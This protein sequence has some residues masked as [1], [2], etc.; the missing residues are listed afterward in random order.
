MRYKK[1]HELSIVNYYQTSIGLR[2]VAPYEGLG[3]WS[4]YNAH[5]ISRY[6]ERMKLDIEDPLEVAVTFFMRNEGF[7]NSHTEKRGNKLYSLASINDGI[8]LGYKQKNIYTW[9]T[10]VAQSMLTKNQARIDNK[11][12]LARL[13]INIK[14][15][16]D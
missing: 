11:N 6:R 16:F 2:F 1:K 8:A 10:F 3:N 9:N 7:K 14:E 5:F 12:V 4:F 13:A 15:A